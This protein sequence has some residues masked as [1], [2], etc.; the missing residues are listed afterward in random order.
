[1]AT[2][3]YKPKPCE[4]CKQIIDVGEECE[5]VPESKGVR[6]WGCG[7]TDINRDDQVALAESLGY[8]GPE[9]DIRRVARD[10]QVWEMPA[11]LRSDSAGRP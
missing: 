10:W 9:A 2:C 6:H 3:L 7:Q 4:Q 11:P 1:M 8:V 5:W